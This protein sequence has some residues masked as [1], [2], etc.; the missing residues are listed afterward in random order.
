MRGR[1]ILKIHLIRD[2]HHFNKVTI[3]QKRIS[4]QRSDSFD[5]SIEFI[6]GTPFL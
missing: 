3:L 1:A 2:E 4:L 6:N 5:S